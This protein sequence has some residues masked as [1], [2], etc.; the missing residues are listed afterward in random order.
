MFDWSPYLKDGEI[1]LWQGRPK[2]NFAAP[3]AVIFI[4]LGIWIGYEKYHITFAYD[5]VNE[6]CGSTPSWSCNKEFQERWE[7]V[8][9]TTI[10]VPFFS[11]ILYLYIRRCIRVKYALTN[12]RI[13]RLTNKKVPTYVSADLSD[14]TTI[15]CKYLS[16]HFFH[17]YL[18]LKYL[19]VCKKGQKDFVIDHST[20]V[21]IEKVE[22]ILSSLG[23]EIATCPSP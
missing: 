10:G 14:D 20:N 21:E 5:T 6:F 9:M 11:I 3:V 13:I 17:E 23:K 19:K 18:K 1:V 22:R 4:I 2:L 8:I 16:S 15:Y 7:G 12:Q